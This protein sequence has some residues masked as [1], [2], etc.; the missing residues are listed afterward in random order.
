M[1]QKFGHVSKKFYLK[2]NCNLIDINMFT[3]V[4]IFKK[5]YGFYGVLTLSHQSNKHYE[6][7]TVS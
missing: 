5:M 6:A 1:T 3:F 7:G 4:Q 2:V